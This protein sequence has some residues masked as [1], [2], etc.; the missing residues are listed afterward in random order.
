V[1]NS[2]DNPSEETPPDVT[3][4][5]DW[6]KTIN[7]TSPNGNKPPFKDT[8]SPGELN[9]TSGLP[10]PEGLTGRAMGSGSIVGHI[11]SG[12]MGDVYKIYNERMNRYHAVKLLR[13]GN[14][15]QGE[16]RFEREIKISA[17]F[18][19]SNIVHVYDAGR[20]KGYLYLEM[21]YVEGETLDVLL[22]KR[23]P[24]SSVICIAMGIFVAKALHYAHNHTY[25][26]DGTTYTGV[27]HRDLKPSNIILAKDGRLKLMD[28][29]IARPMGGELATMTQGIVGSWVYLPPEQ[30]DGSTVDYRA[31]IYTL[32]EVLYEMCT[33]KPPFAFENQR[34]FLNLKTRGKY[35][36]ITSVNG[37]VPE[38]FS[39][40]VDKCLRV[41]PDGR[42]Q[43]AQ[44]L[45]K[46]LQKVYASIT[47]CSPEDVLRNCAQGTAVESG[48]GMK[49]KKRKGPFRQY[50]TGITAFCV[51]LVL[52]GVFFSGSLRG[53]KEK[54]AP[55][56]SPRARYPENNDT[57]RGSSLS[58]GWTNVSGA[59]KYLFHLCSDSAFSDTVHFIP[60]VND[61]SLIIAGPKEKKVLFWRVGVQGKDDSSVRW[62]TTRRLFIRMRKLAAPRLLEP[63]DDKKE[64]PLAMVFHWEKTENADSY[65]FSLAENETFDSPVFDSSNCKTTEISIASLTGNT[66]Y[67]WRVRAEKEGAG[68]D[69]SPAFHFSTG[70]TAFHDYGQTAFDALQKGHLNKAV[71]AI[72]KMDANDKRRDTLLLRVAEKYIAVN[73][74]KSARYYLKMSR[75]NDPYKE[76]LIG[77]VLIA[78]QRCIPAVERLAGITGTATVF[79]HEMVTN[80][81]AYYRAKAAQ[82]VYEKE[83]NE[84]SRKKVLD[85]WEKVWTLYDGTPDHYR[86]REAARESSR[87]AGEN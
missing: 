25:I 32:G 12:G 18:D 71:K 60:V 79:N 33:G 39:R 23:G 58:F 62:G 46:E 84:S 87:I 74:A 53:K 4:P 45:G 76:V 13:H 44:E 82:C 43:T 16:K 36:S 31:D 80:E 24:F 50:M 27:I 54:T 30:L 65:R 73:N 83:K 3:G 55:P 20:W 10:L 49:K 48:T 40:I 59:E 29:G 75:V 61:T 68:S 66:T 41:D 85:A 78:E 77:R 35:P 28:F 81:A 19:N 72:K 21:E 63:A 56:A 57:L 37:T 42:F 8:T 51:L 86:F 14:D 22:K 69:W 64:C 70:D 47:N 15:L 2:P 17:T 34:E 26:L 38:S 5:D 67:F 1:A 11:G 9:S 52:A 7:D 6:R